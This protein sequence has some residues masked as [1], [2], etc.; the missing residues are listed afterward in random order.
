MF[1]QD[2]KIWTR[3]GI[4]VAVLAVIGWLVWRSI[5]R[6]GYI[7]FAADGLTAAAGYFMMSA[8]QLDRYRRAVAGDTEGAL[9]AQLVAR[10]KTGSFD[11]GEAI[12]RVS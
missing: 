11:A 4:S 10:L 6:G 7:R 9:L 2:M 3:L 5:E 8:A 12:N 1:G